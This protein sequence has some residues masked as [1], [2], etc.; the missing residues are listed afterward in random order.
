MLREVYTEATGCKRIPFT[1]EQRRRLAIAGK[2]LTPDERETCCQ[3]V[4]PKTILDW[5]RQM[6][7]LRYDGSKLLREFVEHYN[8]ERHHQGLGGRLIRPSLATANDDSTATVI[9]RRSRLG[10][11]LDFYHRE[12]A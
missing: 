9:R 2:A 7:S 11:L 1:D 12:A 3:L 8:A 4:R 6:T 10:G 5:F